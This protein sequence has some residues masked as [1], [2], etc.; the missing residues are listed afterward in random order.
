MDEEEEDEVSLQRLLRQQRQEE[1][2][3]EGNQV[4]TL[5]ANAIYHAI[6]LL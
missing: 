4:R 6:F 5:A 2:E 3:V 1:E